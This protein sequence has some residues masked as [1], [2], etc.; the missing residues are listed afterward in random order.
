MLGARYGREHRLAVHSCAEAIHTEE[1]PPE[2]SFIKASRKLMFRWYGNNLRQNARALGLGVKRLGAFTSVV[3]FAL[4]LTVLSS[5]IGVIAGALQ[6]FYGGWVDLAGQRF[7][8]IWS[9]KH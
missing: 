8:E 3:L 6:G 1:H 7:L 9:G 4:T 5:I 2:K